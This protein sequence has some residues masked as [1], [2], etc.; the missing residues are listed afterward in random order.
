MKLNYT[1]LSTLLLIVF[2]SGCKK[3]FDEINKNPNGFTSAS[4]GSLFNTTLSSLKS[5]WNEQLYV[6]NSVLYK[7]T[8][9][10]AVP[11]VRW[12][13]YTIGTEEIWAKFR[14]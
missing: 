11:Q 13:N 14:I 6:N 3:D 4:D 10:V 2:V 9:Q 1:L 5:G 8:Q 12:N 7:E